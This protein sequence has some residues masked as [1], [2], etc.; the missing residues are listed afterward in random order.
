MNL[1]LVHG[2]RWTWRHELWFQRQ[3]FF[4]YLR[5]CDGC[6]KRFRKKM[7]SSFGGGEPRRDYCTHRCAPS[8]R[9]EELHWESRDAE[10]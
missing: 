3:R 2:A 5:K 8:S 6:G 1:K 10:H 7:M 4:K 9:W